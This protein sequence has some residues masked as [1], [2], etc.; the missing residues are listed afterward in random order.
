MVAYVRWWH[1]SCLLTKVLSQQWI[2]RPQA[3]YIYRFKLIQTGTFKGLFCLDTK[4]NWSHT[5]HI[6]TS[7]LKTSERES[8]GAYLIH[9]GINSAVQRLTATVWRKQDG[10]QGESCVFFFRGLLR[11]RGGAKGYEDESWTYLEDGK[12]RTGATEVWC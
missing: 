4:A 8:G 5:A 12:C 10:Q 3:R 1:P 7:S 9:P 2:L 6:W 11:T